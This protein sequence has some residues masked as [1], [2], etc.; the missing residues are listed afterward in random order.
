MSSQ[1]NPEEIRAKI[2][3]HFADGDFTGWFETLYAGAQGDTDIVPWVHAEVHPL[4]AEW[5]E[6]N[7]LIGQGKHAI[8]LG[9]GVGD[10]AEKLAELGFDVTGFDI[11]SSAIEWSKQRFPDS[12]VN[13][14]VA[15][16]FDLP[17]AWHGQFDFV[18]E[19]F[20]VQAL[21]LSLREQ[22]LKAIP[23]LL[24]EGGRLLFIC[25]G[26]DHKDEP[27]GP[28]WAISKQELKTL[29]DAGLTIVQEEDFLQNGTSRRFRILYQK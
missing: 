27:Q 26:R 16:L 12:T 29:E 21:P 5:L 14:Q 19:I 18:L 7:T 13:Y 4:F 2:N 8:V 23:P 11:S 1:P 15:N 3:Q 6:N 17:P 25:L 20:T 28:P 10:D 22:A 9:S 24:K